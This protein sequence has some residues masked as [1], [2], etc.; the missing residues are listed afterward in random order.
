MFAGRFTLDLY[1]PEN[2]MRLDRAAQGALHV[3]PARASG[4][5]ATSI[6][7]L[8]NHNRTAMGKRLLRSWLKQPLT[9]VAAI[10]QRHSVVQAF[11]EDAEMRCRP[12]RQSTALP[13]PRVDLTGHQPP[14]LA[15]LLLTV[16]S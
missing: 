12:P 1:N 15:V 5:G 13:C 3:F 6:Y 7:G 8:L 10:Q 16:N 2:F 14:R 4:R 9:D 11:V